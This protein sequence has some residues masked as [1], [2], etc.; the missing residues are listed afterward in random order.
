MSRRGVAS[1]GLLLP[2]P[3]A[4]DLQYLKYQAKQEETPCFPF[5]FKKNVRKLEKLAAITVMTS[6]RL[7]RTGQYNRSIVIGRPMKKVF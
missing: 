2:E 4:T 7:I 5:L 3:E 6:S 1:V